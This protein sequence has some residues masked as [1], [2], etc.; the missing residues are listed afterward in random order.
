MLERVGGTLIMWGLHLPDI[1]PVSDSSHHHTLLTGK[2]VS[3]RLELNEDEG[4]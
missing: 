2:L 3:S 1:R 4:G